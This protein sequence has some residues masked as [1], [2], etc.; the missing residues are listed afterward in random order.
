MSFDI[1]KRTFEK[2]G[3]LQ[4]RSAVHVASRPLPSVL[5]R[6]TRAAPYS[7]KSRTSQLHLLWNIRPKP[8]P[9]RPQRKKAQETKSSTSSKSTYQLPQGNGA[10]VASQP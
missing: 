7:R 10:Q 4:M 1:W 2:M 5:G 9:R 6:Q 3:K 8:A